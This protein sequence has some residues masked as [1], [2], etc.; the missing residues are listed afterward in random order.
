MTDYLNIPPN[1]MTNLEQQIRD[2]W[3]TY[4]PKMYAEM[5]ANGTLEA[6]IE[7]ASQQTK[8][9]VI[10]YSSDPPEGMTPAQAFWAGWETFRE[11]WAFLPAE[12]GFDDDDE[13]DPFMDAQRAMDRQMAAE[14]G[15]PPDIWDEKNERWISLYV[16][17]DEKEE[18]VST[19]EW[20]E[21]IEEWFPAEGFEHLFPIDIEGSEDA[22]NEDADNEA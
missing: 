19:G 15:N 9:A 11:Q 20:D 18:M 7:N 13:P 2:H 8:E 3:S 6:A 10:N 17:D 12:E 21:T 16:W 4:R 5:E 14:M 1:P 22:D